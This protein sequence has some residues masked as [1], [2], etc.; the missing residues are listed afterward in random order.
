MTWGSALIELK[1]QSPVRQSGT[2]LH[3]TKKRERGAGGLFVSPVVDLG[4]KIQ[5]SDIDADAAAAA[6]P[7]K[8]LAAPAGGSAYQPLHSA[9]ECF[10]IERDGLHLV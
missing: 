4:K 3:H 1:H 5:S 2:Y 9:I 10:P 7:A 8:P 6:D